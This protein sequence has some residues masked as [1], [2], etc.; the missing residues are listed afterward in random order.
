MRL[1]QNDGSFLQTGFVPFGLIPHAVPEYQRDQVPADLFAQPYTQ[2]S[3]LDPTHLETPEIRHAYRELHRTVPTLRAALDGLAKAV[4]C[5]DVAVNPLNKEFENDRKAAEFV[6]WTVGASERGWDGLILDICRP[7]LL[8]GWSAL[9]IVTMPAREQVTCST[10]HYNLTGLRHCKSRDTAKLRL[11][12]DVYRNIVGV[13]SLV[14]GQQAF[15][16]KKLLLFTYDEL[17]S[18][19][20]GQSAVRAAMK[21]AQFIE[22]GYKLWHVLLSNTSGPTVVGKVAQPNMRKQMEAALNNLRA[23]GWIVTGEKDSVDLLNFASATNFQAF[24]MKVNKC[25]EEIYLAIRGA[26]LPFT[27]GSGN[28]NRGDTAVSKTAGSDPNETLLAKAVGRAITRQLAPV[29]VSANFP[30]GTGCPVVTLGGVSW[31]ETKQ[32]LEVI[33]MV[34]DLGLSHSEQHIRDISQTPSPADAEDEVPPPSQA[35]GSPGGL[36]G[37]GGPGL[38]PGG[39]APGPPGAGGDP[40]ATG[41]G[42]PAGGDPPPPRAFAAVMDEMRAA[43]RTAI[44]QTVREFTALPPPAGATK[45]V[46]ADPPGRRPAQPPAGPVMV[47]PRVIRVDPERFQ[48]RDDA[49]DESGTTR[50]PPPERFDPAKC[51]PLSCWVDPADGGIYVVDGHHRLEWAVRDGVERVPVTWLKAASAAD[52]KAQGERLNTNRRADRQREYAAIP[53]KAFTAIDPKLKTFANWKPYHSPATGRNGWISDGGLVRYQKPKSSDERPAAEAAAKDAVGKAVDRPHELTHEHVTALEPHLEH[54]TRDQIRALAKQLEQKVGGLKAQLARRVVDE[55]RR[56]AG[57][58]KTVDDQKGGTTDGGTKP[59]G[60]DGRGGGGRDAGGPDQPGGGVAAAPGRPDDCPPSEKRGDRGEPAGQRPAGRVPAQVDRVNQKIDRV[61]RTLRARGQHEAAG[62]LDRLREHVN[63]VGVQSALDALGPDKGTKGKADAQYEGAWATDRVAEFVGPYLARHGISLVN[64]F[65]LGADAGRPL[66][67]SLSPSQGATED[68]GKAGDYLPADPGLANKLEEAK[69]L[70]GLEKSEDI[71][72]VAGKTVTHLTD[73]VIGKLDERYGQG[74]WIVKAYGDDAAAGYGVYFPQYAAQLRRSAQD[75]IWGAGEQLAR[76]GF[77]LDRDASGAVTGIVHSGGDRY[78]FGSPEYERTIGGEVRA[79]ADRA[80]AAA[81]HERGVELPGGGKEF[82]AQ[83][84][85]SVVGISDADRAAGMTIKPG[86]EGRVHVVTRNGRAEV[87]PHSTWLKQE[88]LPVVFESEDTR[89]MA[90]AAVDAINSLPES[91]RAGQ[92]YAPDIVRTA[93]GYKVVEANPANHTG[94]SGY[95][96]DN[97]LVI[98]AYVSHLTGR[99]PA[100]VQFVRGLLTSRDSKP[101]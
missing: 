32:Q 11:Q 83:P 66:V 99:T 51:P 90:Q 84:A 23:R 78:A 36:G 6:K 73:D 92:I 39:P 77:A 71:N 52:A 86:Q 38:P 100:H 26:Y 72:V 49:D 74:R 18:D 24:E 44:E 53:A 22:D 37:L 19:P 29:L 41:L 89:A 20:Y 17:F 61:S 68:R 28:D 12:L 79:A 87:V 97:P 60:P 43:V 33:K 31:A 46:A 59:A 16:P 85:F 10:D 50:P 96:G 63:T 54:L 57:N 45:A 42:P 93:D 98:D 82:M 34:Q 8:D 2:P 95:L 55:L 14:R 5:L 80:A 47:S 9:E 94:S 69:S 76:Y 81:P 1:L 62:W 70:P 67:S 48:F 21:A 101:G 65:D 40:A 7:A 58:P 30:F 25:R 27:E 35:G 75:A 15:D 88:P 56:R 3:A 64:T 4:S 91:E 13:V